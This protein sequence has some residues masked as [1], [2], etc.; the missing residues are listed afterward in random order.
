MAVL[1]VVMVACLLAFWLCICFAML[2]WNEIRYSRRK[3]LPPGTMGWPVLGQTTEFLKHGPSFMKKQ[4]AKYGS[5]FKT[6]ILGC[7]TVISMD[8]E[9]NRYILMNEGKG[10]VPGYPQSMLD[11]LGKCNIAAVHGAAH[12]RIRG[13]LLSLVGPLVIKDECLPKIDKFTRFFLQNWHGKTI[14]I[15]EKTNEGRKRIVQMLKQIMEQRRASPMPYDDMLCRLL[16]SKDSKYILSDEEIIDQIITILYSGY[17][18]VSTTSM[19]AVKYLHDHPKA[20]EELREEHFAIREKKKPG[21]AIDWN[22]YKSMSF[23]RAVIFETSRLATVVNGVLRKTTE[24]MVL[25]G[26]TI[27]KGWRIYVYTRE[28]N[29]DPFLYPE[30]LAFNPWRWLDK[31]L[32]SHSYCFIFGG[33]SRLCPGKELGILQISIFLHYF[34]TSYRWEE[35]GRNEILQFPRVEAPNGLHQYHLIIVQDDDPSRKIEVSDGFDYELYNRNDINRILGPEAACISF[36][37]SACRCLDYLI[38]RKKKYIF[39]IVG[40]G[41]Q[42]DLCVPTSVSHGLWLNIHDYDAPT[43]LVKP[44]ERNTRYVD[45]IMTV[46]KGTLFPMCG[47]NLAFVRELI[48]PAMNFGQYDNMWAGWCMKE[49][50]IPFFQSMVLPKVCNNVE[51]CYLA[52][53][54]EVKSKLGE[55]V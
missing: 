24:D 11:I 17:E 7:P 50:A 25:N 6:H 20:L 26:F 15:Q 16:R 34:I 49:K 9:L 31:N 21:E 39:T 5:V 19:M 35:V 12:K 14:D 42:P 8:P 48:G 22:D 28:I 55:L 53:A 45:A 1:L 47:M 33:G 37:D 23:T 36:K 4:R 10:L 46:P 41:G 30:P 13:S 32:E 2:K 40:E 29:Y 54:G 51:K 27:P 44:L 18:T 3:G 52:A 43:Q 38:P